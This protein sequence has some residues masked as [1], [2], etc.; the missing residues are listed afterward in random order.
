[1]RADS[2]AGKLSEDQVEQ[3]YAIALQHSPRHAALPQICETFGIGTRP[4]KTAF[5]RW[6]GTTEKESWRWRLKHAVSV[7]RT[8]EAALPDDADAIYRNLDEVPEFRGVVTTTQHGSGTV[9]RVNGKPALPSHKLRPGERVDVA[10]REQR[11]TGRAEADMR[12]YCEGLGHCPAAGLGGLSR[13]S[14]NLGRPSYIELARRTFL[15]NIF[16][17]LWHLY[18]N[19]CALER[20][21]S[22]WSGGKCRRDPR[23][24]K[25]VPLCRT[26]ALSQ[27]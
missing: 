22:K 8:M 3:A 10:Q 2:W 7:A 13:P 16:N 23:R 5:Y 25:P 21:V 15:L 24:G 14:R 11:D 6:L 17:P 12:E 26:S 27:H 20:M 18:R 4:S 1:M 9:V 19:Q